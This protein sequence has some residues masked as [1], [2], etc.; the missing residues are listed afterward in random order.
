MTRT[1]R[2]PSPARGRRGAGRLLAAALAGSLAA[3]GGAPE[4]PEPLQRLI[5]EP[6]TATLEPAALFAEETVFAL[7]LAAAGERQL[8]QT[9]GG[10]VPRQTGEGLEIPVRDEGWLVRPVEGADRC[11]AVVVD[12]TWVKEG[13]LELR[14]GPG[15][16]PAASAAPP[17]AAFA[18]DRFSQPPGSRFR[19]QGPPAGAAGAGGRGALALRRARGDPAAVLSVACLRARRDPAA[20]GAAAS[21]PWRVE[22][23]PE[24]RHAVPV[25]PGRPAE[26]EVTVP[27]EGVLRFGYG[28]FEGAPGPAGVEVTLRAPG[29]A[30][31]EVLWRRAEV[32]PGVWHDA[33]V[34]LATHRGRTA[35]LELRAAAADR[36]DRTAGP[37]L[38]AHPAVVAGRREEGTAPNV[39]LI[40]VDTLRADRLE[41]YGY[42]RP[43]MPHLTAWARRRA[44]VFEQAV[45]QAPWTLPSH[46]SMLTG[47]DPLVHGVNF[48]RPAPEP[49]L[50]LPEILHA[51]GYRTL[52]VTG[53]AYLDPQFGL[54]QGFE[55][56]RWFRGDDPREE[57]AG[58]VDTALRW[59][60][61]ERGGA[62]FFL[63]FH[64]YDV[65]EPYYPWAPHLEA[66]SGRRGSF[67]PVVTRRLP[68][69]AENGFA[70]RKE[71]AFLDGPDGRRPDPAL[72]GDLYDSGVAHADGELHRLFSWLE[73]AGIADDT[74]VVFTS[75]H[76]EALGEHGLFGHSS[77]YDHDALVPLV[78]QLPGREVAGRRAPRQVRSIDIVPTVLDV[79]G[80]PVP[81]GLA[82]RS[83]LPLIR[84]RAPAAPDAAV[85][86]A[87]FTNRG[88]A[89]RDGRGHKY[90]LLDQ[91]WKPT[92]GPAEMLFD[93][94]ADPAELR[95]L[96][97]DSERL[98]RLRGAARRLLDG[99][100][101][102][103]RLELHNPADPGGQR[104]CA[105]LRGDA[106][107]IN[108]VKVPALESFAGWRGRGAVG[109]RLPA[110]EWTT[111]I[112]L[113]EGRP[114]GPLRLEPAG[115]GPHFEP[116]DLEPPPAAGGPGRAGRAHHSDYHLAGGRWRPG[117]AAG[118]E[119]TLSVIWR[120]RLP[121]GS[122]GGEP[123]AGDEELEER[124]RALGYL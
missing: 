23:G 17:L 63:F 36:P 6:P 66:L 96:T 124:L 25:L 89:I 88:L 85:T 29:G 84:G 111:L 41:L 83:L 95:P 92:A 46:V 31:S 18:R 38:F 123:A 58:G 100:A 80:L 103:T 56:Y 19:F 65:H 76:G 69:L 37:A 93:L 101:T 1:C 91:A 62:P 120:G 78:I 112:V 122:G 67:Q 35:V 64:T 90:V 53:G 82:G 28:A 107:T 102:G 14:L 49:L 61:E 45:A 8:W 42:P 59:L 55:R 44:V 71:L 81:E 11:Q 108:S 109:L 98:R 39:V 75:D 43:T 24:V 12:T 104:L 110:G 34:D 121:A 26:L 21:R 16:P 20:L 114:A 2:S 118:A 40:S 5:A 113:D 77:V 50:L 86:Y 68:A 13:E 15:S 117:A 94:A 22:L 87:A 7:D 4:P 79:L 106:V 99:S 57:L 119:A 10:A 70:Q 60:G 9:A 74:M 115:C 105:L 30:P 51:H 32:A 116:L 72:A 33:E 3:C 52:A 48:H 27:P 47:L 97:A 54:A 73:E